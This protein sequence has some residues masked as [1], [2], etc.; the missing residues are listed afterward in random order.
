MTKDEALRLAL[1]ALENW[2]EFDPENFGEVDK[3]AITAI[4]AVLEANDEPVAWYRDEDGIRIYYESKVW[5][6]C[7]PLYKK[8]NL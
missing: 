1:E 2:L 4:K 3:K 6:D 5:D 8:D 7:I